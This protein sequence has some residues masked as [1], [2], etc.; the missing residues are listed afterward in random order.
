MDNNVF[1][2]IKQFVPFSVNAKYGLILENNILHRNRI[3]TIQYAKNKIE[4]SVYRINKLKPENRFSVNYE[5]V[6]KGEL[7]F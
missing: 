3:P 2:M 6:P 1:L 7:E 4:E 5:Q